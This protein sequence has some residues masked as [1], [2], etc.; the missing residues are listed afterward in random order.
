MDRLYVTRENGGR[1]LLKVD[2]VI[3]LE[4]MSLAEY[5]KGTTGKCIEKWKMKPLH[6]QYMRDLPQETDL[7]GSFRWLMK[8][9]LTIKTEGTITAAQDQGIKTRAIAKRIYGQRTA[10]RC[11]VCGRSPET[12]LHVLAECSQM[13][14]HNCIAHYVHW[15]LLQNLKI[16]VEVKHTEDDRYKVLWDFPIRTDIPI[17][18]RRPDIFVVDKNN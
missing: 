18:A 16:P 5:E 9:T 8:G 14:R 4:E 12:V 3:E 17:E 1:G 6:G 13:E 10:G 7:T 11:R 15:R 2:D